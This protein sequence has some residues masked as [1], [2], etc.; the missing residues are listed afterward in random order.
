MGTRWEPPPGPDGHDLFWSNSAP[1]LSFDVGMGS[2]V[3]RKCF[4][5][6][7]SSCDGSVDCSCTC[8]CGWTE[9]GGS[10]KFIGRAFAQ[11]SSD[12][13]SRGAANRC[14]RGRPGRGARCGGRSSTRAPGLICHDI[15]KR[16]SRHR[17][18]DSG[19]R[20]F[21]IDPSFV[22]LE[23]DH[24]S[25]PPPTSDGTT[26]PCCFRRPLFSIGEPMQRNGQ[27]GGSSCR[28]RCHCDQQ[29]QLVD[30][31]DEFQYNGYR[32]SW[33]GQRPTNVHA[34]GDQFDPTRYIGD[35]V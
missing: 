22:T 13:R 24:P 9:R 21:S 20:T 16:Q 29:S 2:A 32:V 26:S 18:R 5:R 7:A 17:E 28:L 31:S 11:L 23:S 6:Y 12:Q 34:M 3:S 25:R 1:R 10:R 4:R 8:T 27:R 14:A 30:R 35:A 19:R 33:R 15:S